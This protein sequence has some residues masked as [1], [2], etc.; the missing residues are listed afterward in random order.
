MTTDTTAMQ[1]LINDLEHM[2]SYSANNETIV[3]TV[4]QII[5]DAK[6]LLTKEKEQIK[7]AYKQGSADSFRKTVL[8]SEH[9]FNQ[10]YLIN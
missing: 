7:L 2:K 5:C 6:I 9:Y 10:T 4:S 1:K 8:P 3:S